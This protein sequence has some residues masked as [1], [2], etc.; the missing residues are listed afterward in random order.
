MEM[1]E[2]GS[3]LQYADQSTINQTRMYNPI[4]MSMLPVR[5]SEMH[6]ITSSDTSTSNVVS[7]PATT[8]DVSSNSSSDNSTDSNNDLSMDP[9]PTRSKQP[10]S[11]SLV[12]NNNN[13]NITQSMMMVETS[14]QASQI[15]DGVELTTT[16]SGVM[17]SRRAVDATYTLVEKSIN[18]AT[19]HLANDDEETATGALIEQPTG[20]YIV[21]AA[22]KS[23]QLKQVEISHRLFLIHF[24]NKNFSYFA[25]FSDE[26]NTNDAGKTTSTLDLVLGEQDA[27]DKLALV[28][29]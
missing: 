9:L 16:I 17:V 26:R 29:Y 6:S 24:N 27:G 13:N 14:R 11:R 23:R 1:D 15:A 28:C 19:G 7:G 25:Q 5:G 10:I 20:T 21:S 18:E 8:D 4:D 2:D 3:V 12:G 22:E